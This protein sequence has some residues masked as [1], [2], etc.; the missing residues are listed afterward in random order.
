MDT[1]HQ[2]MLWQCPKYKVEEDGNRCQLR[3]N[4]TRLKKKEEEKKNCS[5]PIYDDQ[6]SFIC[7]FMQQTFIEHL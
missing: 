5:N 6:K 2:A 3:A 4:L 7:M 1:T